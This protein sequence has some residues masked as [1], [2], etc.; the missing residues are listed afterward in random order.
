MKQ[1][2]LKH[3]KRHAGFTLVE[4]LVV[5]AIIAVIG[6]G[7]AVTYRNLDDKAQTAMEISD[8]SI[9]KKVIAQWSAINDEKLPDGLDSLVTI[10]GDLYSTMPAEGLDGVDEPADTSMGV[11]GPLGYTLAVEQAP[12]V[13]LNN[14]YSA[15]LTHVY[16]HLTGSDN[17][18]GNANDSTWEAGEI[19]Y[20][21]MG[22][23]GPSIPMPS[24]E[25]D[26]SRT[27]YAL[28]G[29]TYQS[30]VADAEAMANDEGPENPDE[31]DWETGYTAPDGNTYHTLSDF[32]QAKEEAQQLVDAPTTD[33]L[34]FIW[35]G[36]GATMSGAPAP[37][38]MSNEIIT[39]CGYAPNEIADPTADVDREIAAGKK[40][41][42]VAFGLGRF[43][44]IYGAKS[45]R[46]DAPAYGKR[47][48]QSTAYYN[49][50]LVI[51]SV[52]LEAYSSMTGSVQLPAV[53][54][55]LTPQGYSVASL[56]D[57][58]IA[59]EERVKD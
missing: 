46:V 22:P 21:P 2:H 5:V 3:T 40:C 39:N 13:V 25:V 34:A 18:N 59:D 53:V 36:S 29:S 26:T 38:N 52:P 28:N 49:R 45:I 11:L 31:Y 14:L 24:G 12:E 47:L 42:L 35:S 19:T 10:N 55:V 8:C 41:Y 6:A 9:L 33:H 32:T 43:A 20:Q 50:Y 44:S 48:G 4:L 16:R 17:E 30:S 7:V 23:G 54:D 1:N 56:R 27:L 51:V 57:K 15:G 58:Y 37:M